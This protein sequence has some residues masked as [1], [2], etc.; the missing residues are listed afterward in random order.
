MNCPVC[1]VGEVHRIDGLSH[2][3]SIGR[4]GPTQ[5][6]DSANAPHRDHIEDTDREP[7]INL[8]LLR[9]VGNADVAERRVPVDLDDAGSWREK[10][11]KRSQQRGLA[12]TVRTDDCQPIARIE[13]ERDL[14]KGAMTFE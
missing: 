7:P 2:D 13:V 4:S 11:G 14:G 10:S 9:H 5:G 3:S 6:A 8:Y 12:C 1:E